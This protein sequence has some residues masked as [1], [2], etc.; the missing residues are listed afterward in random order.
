M[1]GNIGI[2]TSS[3][4]Q[5]LT[6]NGEIN[7]PNGWRLTSAWGADVFTLKKNAWNGSAND[8]YGAIAAGHGYFYN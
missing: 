8:N 1:G 4:T 6:V 5:K 2:G 7:Y 3:P